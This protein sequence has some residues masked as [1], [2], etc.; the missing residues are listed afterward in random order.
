[1]DSDASTAHATFAWQWHPTA[2]GSELMA[3]PKRHEA[4]AEL[5]NSSGRWTLV[6][7]SELDGELE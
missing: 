2:V 6:Q 5:T 4:K 3:T 1:M 7:I